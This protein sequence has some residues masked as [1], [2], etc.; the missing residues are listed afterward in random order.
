MA[1]PLGAMRIELD[2]DSS[3]FAS[4]LN[5]SK[6][7]VNYFKAEARALD[8]AMK[9]SGN[10]MTLLSAKQKTLTQAL[11]KQ[12]EVLARLKK[13]FNSLDVG[14]KKWESAAIEIERENAKLEQL[15]A[16]LGRVET[17]LVK[18]HAENSKWGKLGASLTNF[19]EGAK[20]VGSVLTTMGNAMMP[21]STALSAGFTLATKKAL[22]FG[23]EMQTVKALLSDTITDTKTLNTT[24]AQLGDNSKKWA[25]QFGISTSDINLGMQEIIKA[26]FDANQTIGAMPA[27]LTA[28]K[29]T[30]EAFGTVMGATTSI[31]SQFNLITSDTN[32]MLKNTNR[33]T[34]SLSFVA[35][36][37]KAGF[38]DMGLAME[39]VGPVANSVGMSIEETAAAIGILSNAGI[40][41]QKAGTALRGALSK[42]LDP[43]KENAAAFE[44]LGFSAEEFRSGAI[45]LP[46]VIDRIRKNTEG[47]TAAQ[48]AAIIA[49][50]FGIEAQSGIN[51]LVSA[52]ADELNK[53]TDATKGAAGYTD[54]LYKKMSGSGK[55]A[56]DRFRS[57][58]EVLQITVGEK[59]LPILTPIIEKVT[60]WVEKFAEADEGTQK[61]W[62]TIAGGLAVA[63]P[64]LNFVGN[65]ATGIG[66]VSS[67]FGF[68]STKMSGI[69]AKKAVASTLSS[70]ATSATTTGT[71]M[72]GAAGSA[73]LLSSAVGLLGN[74]V[75][76][77]VLLGG[78]AVLVG[79]AMWAEKA[80]EAAQR[81]A[82]W[83][84]AVS[85]TEAQELSKFKSKVD[86]TNKAMTLFGTE[87]V[88]DV[89]NVKQAFSELTGEIAKLVDEN[90]AKD[91]KLAEKLG[92]SDEEIQHMKDQAEETKQV[93]QNMAQD[94][95]DIYKRANEEKRQLSAEEKEIV[96]SAQ[97][98]LIQEQLELMKFS[99][100][101]KEALTKAMN[102]RI[103]EL[104]STQLAKALSNTKKMI[105][106]ERKAYKEQKK[107]IEQLYKERK[108]SEETYHREMEELNAQ[109][110]AKMDAFGEQY[111]EIQKRLLEV[112][113]S[114]AKSSP[115]A[116]KLILNQVKSTMQALGLSYEEF[117][118][119][120]EGVADKV[121][122]TS[123]L[124]AGY[125]Q[126]MS[127]EARTAVD[128]WNGIVLDPVTGEVKT[129]AQEEIQRALQ[130]EGGWEA[131]QLSLK[132]GRLTTTA[133]VAIG[134]ALVATG[135][136]ESLSPQEKSLVV[137]GKPAIKAIVESKE[138]LAIWNSMPEGVKKLL[139]EN[140]QFLSSAET[141]KATLNNWNLLQPHQKAL[142]ADDLA[143]GNA[144][145]AQQAINALTGKTVG[146]NA[147]DLPLLSKVVESNQAV[148]SLQQTNVPVMNAVDGTG[149]AVAQAQ[150]GVNSPHQS[151]PIGIFAQNNTGG[152]VVQAQSL[153]DGVKQQSPTSIDAVN[154]ASAAAKQATWDLNSIPR[155]IT[156]TIT[157][158]VEKIFK[159]EKGTDFHPGGM[160]MVNDQKGPLYRELITLPSGESFIPEGRDVILP[161]PRGSKV[162]P[163][164]QT[165]DLM[166]MRGIPKYAQG[167]GYPEDARIFKDIERYNAKSA[168]STVV[169]SS[170]DT[171]SVKLLREI[172]NVLKAIEDKDIDGVGDVYLGSDKVGSIID[173]YQKNNEWLMNSMKGVN[174]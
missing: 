140:Q 15:R 108:I 147:D 127:E 51:A 26:G 89:E 142:I 19:G 46:D 137:D 131:M 76:W 79:V 157:T 47:M 34:D 66:N 166:Q 102:G 14:S 31:M 50:A 168:K 44:Q 57:S 81:T 85:K 101:E 115:E 146:L 56:V 73:G 106:E 112:N 1:T 67:A 71:A 3:K 171:V 122:A 29:A 130:A 74:P 165:R 148:N 121:S 143:S 156:S 123:S 35:N 77:G 11:D 38:S 8:A 120:M 70:V 10:T 12:G 132:E 13:N 63:Y 54:E 24:T 117:Q 151:S 124:V 161:L 141:A 99:S 49:Q 167:V 125:W 36:K 163:A 20:K 136:W 96:L 95:V 60:E 100:K 153:V 162:L 30:G 41:G 145:S 88:Q 174:P 128:Y 82:E 170:N 48:K 25:K 23:G 103:E 75:T 84:T 129:N 90:L 152:P 133:K 7:A 55:S 91:L 155:T 58:L 172:L 9:S 22:D 138:N 160:A 21:V 159:N 72:A 45:K 28:S 98:A 40:D 5:A 173:R 154:N 78:G 92:L 32:Q 4:N 113:G 134:E 61:F 86:E 64:A 119:K 139:G 135:Q 97:N 39:Y 104:N 114:L 93:T 94:V 69:L 116:Q 164:R 62:M 144:A 59:L 149:P 18:V 109:H 16:E 126:G 169:V 33:V 105:E 68:L 107:E 158:F 111:M 150:T 6:K 27:I 2:L 110:N 53:L 42:L 80:R 83:G 87:G 37:T 118:A 52:G 65:L 17:A 43:S